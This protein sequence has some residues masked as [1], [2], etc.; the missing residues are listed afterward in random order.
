MA[1]G[2]RFAP[3]TEQERIFARAYVRLGNASAAAREADY[4]FPARQG[5][6]ALLKKPV[7]DEVKRLRDQVNASRD[8]VLVA[9]ALEVRERV[10]WILR[11]GESDDVKLKAA[12]ILTKLLYMGSEWNAGGEQPANEVRVIDAKGYTSMS[13]AD[14]EAE[15][16]RIGRKLLKLTGGGDG[17]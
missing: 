7:Q 13:R 12:A 14:L 10:T 5:Y 11:H 6:R 16:R 4:A 8:P 17:G 3:M 15:G 2:R 1:K 9:D